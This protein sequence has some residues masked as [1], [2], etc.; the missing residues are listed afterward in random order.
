MP[1]TPG[2]WT[3]GADPSAI[4]I[5]DPSEN[6][7]CEFTIDS[8]DDIEFYSEVDSSIRPILLDEA[9]SNAQLFMAVPELLDALKALAADVEQT[10]RNSYSI[11]DEDF[12]LCWQE[13]SPEDFGL[14]DTAC[15][16]IAHAEGK[17]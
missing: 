17:S 6:T 3:I 11:E 16:A 15:K 9:R 2:P 12:P 8:A 10:A 7:V 1:H 13:C 4:V 14:W 5:Q